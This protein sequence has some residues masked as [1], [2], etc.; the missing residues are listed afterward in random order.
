MYQ[1]SACCKHLEDGDSVRIGKRKHSFWNIPVGDMLT[2][3]CEPRPW[4]NK[5]VA[6]AHNTKTFDLNFI[7]SRAI[8]LKWKLELFMNDLK[9]MCM[10]MEHMV[11]L[12]SVCFLPVHCVSC[13][14]RSV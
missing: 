8:K 11:F 7:L 2:Y 14:R 4:A 12:Y 13:T 3:L 10:K 1:F 9:V 5:I 6:I